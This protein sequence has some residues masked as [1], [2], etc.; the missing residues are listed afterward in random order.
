MFYGYLKF[1]FSSRYRLRCFS[2][3]ALNTRTLFKHNTVYNF[4]NLF[5]LIRVERHFSLTRLP[6][7]NLEN[8]KFSYI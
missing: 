7:N 6:G 8:L 1:K 2:I 4:M 5:R 3:V